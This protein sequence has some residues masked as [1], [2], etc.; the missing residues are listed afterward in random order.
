LH[1]EIQLYEQNNILKNIAFVSGLLFLSY[2]IF[3]LPGSEIT[4]IE[5]A[6]YNWFNQSLI[7]IK[8]T[9]LNIFSGSNG[10]NGGAPAPN[11]SGSGSISP[12]TS[13]S[14]TTPTKYFTTLPS[15]DTVEAST[16]TNVGGL[17]VSKMEESV[18]ILQ[19]VLDEDASAHLLNHVS[20]K[21]KTITD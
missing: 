18:N 3:A 10:G 15:I 12:S 7:E 9:I 16:Q 19:D 6:S 4:P 11:T 17:T 13:S 14:S 1:E 8:L 20:S 21:I 2:F 5:L